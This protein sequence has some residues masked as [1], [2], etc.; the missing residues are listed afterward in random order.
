MKTG[1]LG[2][3]LNSIFSGVRPFPPLTVSPPASRLNEGEGV[4]GGGSKKCNYRLILAD[5]FAERASRAHIFDY[6]PLRASVSPQKATISRHFV[7]DPT[8]ESFQARV[9][10]TPTT[11]PTTFYPTR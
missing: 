2:H 9:A 7:T 6:H 10:P 4:T 1:V 3:F 8:L 5:F 11:L